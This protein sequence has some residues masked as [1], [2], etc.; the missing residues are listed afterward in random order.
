MNVLIVDD[1]PLIHEIICGVVRGGFGDS[2]IRTAVDLASALAAFDSGGEPDLI[3]LDLCLPD[4]APADTLQRM[5]GRYQ[6]API[7]VLSADSTR[8]TILSA[9][10]NGAA[11]YLPKS[12]KPSI[13]AAALKLVNSGGVYIPAEAVMEEDT[14]GAASHGDKLNLTNRQKEVLRLIARGHDNRRIAVHLGISEGTV[15]QHVHALFIALDI[16]SRAQAVRA[17]FRSGIGDD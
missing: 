17:A 8:D 16:S 2:E 15:K 3:I 4:S 9:L 5:H 13:M 14:E 12:L 6:K 11:G 10:K 7:V 1:H